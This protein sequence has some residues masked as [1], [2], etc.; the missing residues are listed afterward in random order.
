ME[1]FGSE[2]DTEFSSGIFGAQ[3][4]CCLF[5]KKVEHPCPRYTLP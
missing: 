5:P 4:F 1:G 2:I 3:V